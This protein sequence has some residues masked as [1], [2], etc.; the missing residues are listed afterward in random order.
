MLH[1]CSNRLAALC[2]EQQRPA[3]LAVI[4]L[5][6]SSY[7]PVDTPLAHRDTMPFCPT[8]RQRALPLQVI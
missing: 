3:T 6:F 1:N 7:L 2:A 5:T 8:E 4:T